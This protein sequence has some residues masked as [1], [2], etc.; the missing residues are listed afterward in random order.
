MKQP[1]VISFFDEATFTAS[2]IVKDPDSNHAAII[3]SVLDYDAKSGR[4]STDSADAIISLAQA[5]GLSIDWILETHAHADHLSAAVYLQ[6]KLGGKIA[7]GEHI[8]DVQK[9]FRDVFNFEKEFLPDGTQ[10]DHLFADGDSFMIGGLEAKVMHTPGHT[11]ACITFLAGDAAFVGDTLFMPDSGTARADFPGGDARAL[12]DSTQKLLALPDETRVFLCHDYGQD[13]RE[14]TCETTIAEQRAKNIHVG[15][16]KDVEAYV[17]MREAR[18][19]A[20]AM[21]TLILPSIQVNIRGGHMP[22]AEENGTIYLK[23]P[24]NRL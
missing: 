16:G 17:A 21:P 22:P 20:L 1:I 10:F 13:G 5:Q 3:D 8:T 9:I 23:V 14:I 11:P 24:L 2:Y 6:E 12:Y 15:E 18:D 4:T 7:I 19:K